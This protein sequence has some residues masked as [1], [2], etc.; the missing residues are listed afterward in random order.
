MFLYFTPCYF[1]L[2]IVITQPE[3]GQLLPWHP[4]DLHA[5]MYSALPSAPF[6]NPQSSENRKSFPLFFFAMF[7]P[8]FQCYYPVQFSMR[9]SLYLQAFSKRAIIL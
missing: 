3:S 8:Q 6:I 7:S 4:Q 2:K 9:L 5:H 1:Q